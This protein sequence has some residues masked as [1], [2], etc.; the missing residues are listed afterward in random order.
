MRR[1]EN[2]ITDQERFA[3]RLNDCFIGN[4]R[5]E[6]LADGESAFKECRNLEVFHSTFALRYPFWHGLSLKIY[7]C[8]FYSTCR[9]PFWYS[10]A[11]TIQNCDL[12]SDKAFRECQDIN[13]TNCRFSSDECFWKSKNIRMSNCIFNGEYGFLQAENID[14]KNLTFSG[15]YSFQYVKNG[16]INN[17]KLETKDAL[18]HSE[19]ITVNEC[20]LN[21]EY[22][23]WYSK[24]LTL[25][26]CKIISKQPLCYCKNLKLVDCTFIN[27]D[28]AFE[29]SEVNG[30]ITAHNFSIYN[31][32]SGKL[33]CNGEY[34]V[35]EDE[36]TDK[37]SSLF[38]I[39]KKFL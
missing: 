19:N 7:E 4:T 25:I 38:T 10:N 31:P 1:I 30:N 11:I 21:G 5:I 20:E 28:L 35:I 15:K 37:T 8:L 17:S 33:E 2:I 32:L 13:V 29:K 26:R 39:E 36:F 27:C 12:S 23:G 22:L 6:G 9:G 14:I 3:Y 34:Q 24:N 16:I 18:W